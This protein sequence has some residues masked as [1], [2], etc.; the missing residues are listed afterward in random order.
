MHFVPLLCVAM[1]YYKHT[2]THLNIGFSLFFR[3]RFEGVFNQVNHLPS[4]RPLFGFGH[5]G[6]AVDQVQRHSDRAVFFKC[7]HDLPLERHIV[8]EI[9]IGLLG[10]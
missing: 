7:V 1:V 2:T 9:R 5:N 4:K 6:D 3:Q 8:V 10:R